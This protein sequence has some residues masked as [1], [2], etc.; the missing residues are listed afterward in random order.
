MPAR[1]GVVTFESMWTGVSDSSLLVFVD[2][3]LEIS[4]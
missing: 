3:N 1:A 2:K 4:F